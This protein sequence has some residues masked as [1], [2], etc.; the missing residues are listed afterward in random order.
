MG[1]FVIIETLDFNDMRMSFFIWT[2]AV[3]LLVACTNGTVYDT[4]ADSTLPITDVA[5]QSECPFEDVEITAAEFDSA[6][7]FADQYN[8]IRSERE[9][10]ATDTA[11]FLEWLKKTN[12]ESLFDMDECSCCTFEGTDFIEMGLGDYCCTRFHD[13]TTI[14]P[15][16]NMRL[17][18]D[19]FIAGISIEWGGLGDEPTYIYFYPCDLMGKPGHPLIYQTTP[20]WAPTGR[21]EFWNSGWFFVEGYDR[22]ADKYVYHKVRP[23]NEQ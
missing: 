3:V 8:Y 4:V 15:L 14:M 18:A 11:Y 22:M 21:K 13:D 23:K 16:C 7:F 2:C 10:N 5:T 20:K 12:Q 19:G 6:K 9:P 17:T 1:F